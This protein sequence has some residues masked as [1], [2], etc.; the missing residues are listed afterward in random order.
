MSIDFVKE[1]NIVA[2]ND[3]YSVQANEHHLKA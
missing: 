3:N 2:L 1:Q